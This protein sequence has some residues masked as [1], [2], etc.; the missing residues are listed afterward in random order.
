VS[1]VSVVDTTKCYHADQLWHCQLST[2][3]RAHDQ[4]R[5]FPGRNCFGQRS[6][7]QFVREILL[8]CEEP[9]ECSALERAVVADGTAQH[10]IPCFERVEDGT[11]RDRTCDFD[12]NFASNVGE[13][14]EMLWEFDSN[15]AT[16]NAAQLAAQK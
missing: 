3:D 1:V 16:P 10:G 7:G 4:K 2:R 6:V 15:H 13:G 11:L 12:F 8:A 14:A 5:F 9:Q